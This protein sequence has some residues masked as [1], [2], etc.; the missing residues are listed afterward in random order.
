MIIGLDIDDV[1]FDTNALVKIVLTRP[2][3]KQLLDIKLEL[4]RGDISK[5]GVKNFLQKNL[6]FAVRNA[7]PM[8]GAA[9]IIHKLRKSGHKIVLITARGD[10]NFPGTVAAN[11]K[12][13][14]DA[15]IEYDK[16]IYDSVDKVDA[17]RENEVEVF[18]DDSPRNCMEV[19]RILNIPVIGFESDVTRES[20]HEAG[21]PSVDNWR[22]LERNL[23]EIEK[24]MK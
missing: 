14:K 6:I 18:I 13:L 11:E 22:E 20:L 16:I 24:E 15:G 7:K 9:E 2:E 4:M 5:P 23:L 19:A 8:P 3:N 17:C 1:I 12:A 21:I 10:K